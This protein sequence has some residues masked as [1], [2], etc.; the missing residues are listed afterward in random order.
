MLHR[1]I[2]LQT[3][4]VELP[5]RHAGGG[6][7]REG[8]HGI[9]VGGCAPVALHMENLAVDIT[10]RLHA[11]HVG[12][13]PLRHGSRAAHHGER[14]LDVGPRNDGAAQGEGEPLLHG[15]GYHE[16]GRDV[17]RTDVGGHTEVSPV[18]AAAANVE[19]GK[20]LAL[21]VADV[22]SQGP[23]RLHKGGNGPLTHAFGARKDM[24]L[25]RA[26]GKVGRKEAHGGAGGLN[27]DDLAA[28]AQC[29]PHDVRVVAGGHVFNARHGTT[30]GTKQHGAVADALGSGQHHPGLQP[31]GKD[32]SV[33]HKNC[34]LCAVMTANL[35][36]FGLKL[37]RTSFLI[38]E[39]NKKTA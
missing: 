7:G 33:I 38:H 39:K 4:T 13:H 2:A 26:D 32:G 25:A 15:G 31:G 19:R 24:F 16:E 36:F 28:L 20:A 35:V 10:S 11:H 12:G 21:H 6:V 8:D 9:P 37:R 27:V 1:R 30:Q 18:Q 29:T 23:Q 22:G 5:E 34:G 17:L 14:H 3:L